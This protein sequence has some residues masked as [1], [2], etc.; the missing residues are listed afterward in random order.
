MRLSSTS[1]SADT[2]FTVFLMIS[3]ALFSCEIFASS[4]SIDDYK[5]SFYFYLDIIATLS[6][7]SD[8]DV[9]LDFV[10]VIFGM[11]VSTE[12]VDALPGILHI[13]NALN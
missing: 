5:Y 4:I 9:L 12:S 6:I 13:E 2:Y 7:I 3:F 1:K 11:S 8:V 10:A